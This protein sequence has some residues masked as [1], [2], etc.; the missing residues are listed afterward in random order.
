MVFDY[1]TDRIREFS[2]GIKGYFDIKGHTELEEET[3]RQAINEPKLSAKTANSSDKSELEIL[4]ELVGRRSVMLVN[5]SK[6][7]SLHSK[8]EIEKIDGE[9]HKI[10]KDFRLAPVRVDKEY[11][12]RKHYKGLMINLAKNSG[13]VLLLLTIASVGVAYFTGRQVN[14]YREENKELNENLKDSKKTADELIKKVNSST[15]EL[16]SLKKDFNK[17]KEELNSATAFFTLKLD[18]AINPLAGRL[19]FFDGILTK[20]ESRISGLEEKLIIRGEEIY[21]I[22]D[23]LAA[24]TIGQY[25]KADELYNKVTELN[26]SI[27]SFYKESQK[28]LKNE[29]EVLRNSLEG[30]LKKEADELNKNLE[31]LRNEK[32]SIKEF[33]DKAKEIEARLKEIKKRLENPNV[34]Q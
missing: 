14:R 8:K 15:E 7:P 32:M 22:N 17:E 31:T 30:E 5:Y 1:I 10:D 2:A 19:D 6:Y 26:E 27:N 25:V 16:E 13:A 12:L 24:V 33:N 18:E 11:W 21:K 3:H 20:S 28:N 23:A 4:S 34:N 29:L 9:I